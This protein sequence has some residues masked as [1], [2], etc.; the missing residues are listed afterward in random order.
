MNLLTKRILSIVFYFFVVFLDNLFWLLIKL[1]PNK[2]LLKIIKI[3]SQFLFRITLKDQI[4][5]A[6]NRRLLYIFNQKSKT[7]S[8]FS[9]CLSRSITISILLYII[10]VK[11][12]INIG[13]YKS[14]DGKY[15]P[16]AWVTNESNQFNLTSPLNPENVAKLFVI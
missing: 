9:N 11:T 2:I 6:L 16:H 13:M 4:R 8:F 10:G 5:I 1:L 7:K 3:R 14:S 12:N 15:T